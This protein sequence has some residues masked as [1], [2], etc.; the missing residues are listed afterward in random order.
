MYLTLVSRDDDVVRI[1]SNGPITPGSTTP[2]PDPL[3]NLLND[4]LY[5]SRIVWNMER[6]DFVNSNGIGW[7]LICHKRFTE[8]GGKLVFYSVP[9]LTQQTF[10]LLR[11]H[12]VFDLAADEKEAL[13]IVSGAKP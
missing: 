8:S 9:P 6:S 4:D 13:T 7:L 10:K 2:D 12:Q 5:T 3:Q 11:L 1:R